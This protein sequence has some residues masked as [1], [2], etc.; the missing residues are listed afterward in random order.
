MKGV[1]CFTVQEGWENGSKIWIYHEGGVQVEVMWHFMNFLWFLGV[2][3]G[4]KGN[5][6]YYD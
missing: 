5:Q 3:K 2:L 1:S 4:K 6:E